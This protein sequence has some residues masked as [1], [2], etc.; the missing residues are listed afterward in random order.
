[1]CTFQ[2]AAKT[3]KQDLKKKLSIQKKIQNIGSCCTEQK[4]KSE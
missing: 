3:V 2:I 1:M 4:N